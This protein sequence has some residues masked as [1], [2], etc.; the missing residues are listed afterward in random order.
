M[1][2]SFSELCQLS[3]NNPVLPSEVIKAKDA[4]VGSIIEI[5]EGVIGKQTGSCRFYQV[6]PTC[7]IIG[8]VTGIIIKDKI[9]CQ[10]S[11]GST[12]RL[13]AS[14][15]ERTPDV[16]LEDLFSTYVVAIF[17]IDDTEDQT[18][19]LKDVKYQDLSS[20]NL[21]RLVRESTGREID[22]FS[23][24]Y[25]VDTDVVSVEE[26]RRDHGS[27]QRRRY[28]GKEASGK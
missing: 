22:D 8:A 24:L 10:I 1:N 12:C 21:R 17:G 27:K 20:V 14:M 13:V 5:T 4:A 6:E 28:H 23:Y 15:L 16:A 19:W 26:P 2:L 9:K 11:P 25:S 3:K 18:I 7:P